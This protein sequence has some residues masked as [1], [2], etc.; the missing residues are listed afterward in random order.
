MSLRVDSWSHPQ[1]GSSIFMTTAKT[2][3]Q[4]N[5]VAK[6]PV[7]CNSPAGKHSQLIVVGIF[8]VK[9][10]KNERNFS[11]HKSKK[12]RRWTNKLSLFWAV[13]YWSHYDGPIVKF[14]FWIG[15]F[16]H[17]DTVPA[18]SC[19]VSI[20]DNLICHVLIKCWDVMQYIC[21]EVKGMQAPSDPIKCLKL[22]F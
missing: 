17:R 5:S 2:P 14:L 10:K 9:W 4:L 8:I 15:I 18:C 22:I 7:P 6:G 19:I 3:K 21:A 1:H 13:R 20:Y 16:Y 11:Q 12:G